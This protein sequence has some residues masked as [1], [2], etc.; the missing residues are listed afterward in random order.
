MNNPRNLALAAAGV[1]AVFTFTPLNP[2][3]TPAVKAVGEAHA[4]GGGTPTHK[5]AIATTRAADNDPRHEGNTGMGTDH[6]RD[7]V[8]SQ[9]VGDPGI[10]KK[11][12]NTAMTGHEA[13]RPSGENSTRL[14][15]RGTG[16]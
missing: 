16:E 5:P 11:K 15:N 6:F 2:F 12:F 3:N 4:R 10:L 14:K 9:G 7:N 1:A 8:A 13:G